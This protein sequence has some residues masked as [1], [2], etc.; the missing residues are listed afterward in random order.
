MKSIPF[1]EFGSPEDVAETVLFLVSE[2]ARYITGE[3]ID[4]NG[5]L[6]MD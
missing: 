5:G 4:V 3:I 1:G 6:L 2:K